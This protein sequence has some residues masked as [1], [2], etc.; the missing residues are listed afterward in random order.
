M[1]N[2]NQQ[3]AELIGSHRNGKYIGEEKL[4]TKLRGL[5]GTLQCDPPNSSLYDWSGTL[6]LEGQGG[7]QGQGT[8]LTMKTTQLLMGGASLRKTSWAVGVVVYTGMQTKLQMNFAQ[9]TAPK[10]TSLEGMMNQMI[11]ALL[12]VQASTSPRHS[13][14]RANAALALDAPPRPS[15]IGR[16]T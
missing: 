10:I 7:A 8:P 9:K 14:A 1:Y 15:P 4:I 16:A 6:T 13:N 12:V 11:M 5:K 2:A 3:L